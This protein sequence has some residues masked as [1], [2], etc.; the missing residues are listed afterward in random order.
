MPYVF[1]FSSFP[2]G[3]RRQVAGP[4]VGWPTPG[5]DPVSDGAPR[6]L[7]SVM[8]PVYQCADYLRE[9][10]RSV[11][12][13]DPGINEME[14]E[15]VDNCS[16]DDPEAVVRELGAGRVRFYRQPRNV[17]AVENFN[18]CIRRARGEWV[19]ILHADDL[20]RPG[21]FARARLAAAAYPAAGAF[22]CRLIYID[23][24][25]LWTGLS[26]LEARSAGLL[27]EDFVTRQ[28]LEQRI[29]FAGMVVRRSV[30]EKLG[31]FRPQLNHCTDWDMWNRVVSHTPVAYDPEPLA[32]YRMHSRSDTHRVVRSGEN[33]A[34]ERR[35]IG[36]SCA[37]VAP[38]RAARLR[39]DALRIAA[40][41]AS[42]RVRRLWRSGDHGAALRQF[43]EALRCSMA[44]AVV[45]RLVGMFA[46]MLIERPLFPLPPGAP[47][48]APKPGP[49][50]LPAASIEGSRVAALK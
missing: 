45:A 11:L 31:G 18:T 13:Q 6:P 42:R 24:N 3:G 43:R 28:L 37:Y 46:A 33:V 7:W 32:Y 36:L 44:P 4:P 26:E 47:G 35:A 5:I 29:Q 15:V 23:E 41:R 22:A 12:V 48:A 40:I 49:Q 14:I 10:L 27:D 9:T 39:R 25:G 38:E 8:I 50:L 21:F 19:H 30:Y 16:S 17:G 2:A 1:S 34:D 20:V